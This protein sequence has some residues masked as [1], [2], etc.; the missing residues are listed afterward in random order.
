M[1]I[2]DPQIA[3]DAD[4]ICNHCTEYFDVK[5][6]YLYQGITG[7]QKLD[8]LVGEVR[9]AGR[10]GAY[11]CVLGLSGGIDSSYAAYLI[12]SMGLRP[13]A[14]HMD[15]GWDSEQSVSNI[16]KMTSGLGIDY[17]SYVLDWEEFRELQLSFLRAA[18]PEA[19]TPTDMAIIAAL[20]A[21]AAKYRVKHIVSAGNIT[22]EGILPKTWHYNAKDA[23]YFKHIHKTFGAG[24]LKTFPVFDY[25]REVYY[26]LVK[27]IKFIYPLDCVRF[28]RAE[29]TSFLEEKFDYRS[30]GEK[31]SESRYT[32]FIQSYYLFEKFG[33][34]YRRARLSSEICSGHTTRELAL[35]QLQTRPFDRTTIAREKQYVA[36]KLC[37]STDELDALVAAP[38]KRY[39]DYPN[40]ERK[41]QFIYGLYLR[42]WGKEKLANY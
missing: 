22:T 41:L 1:D 28:S 5:T 8:E 33:L 4:G 30:P 24:R 32:R 29:I 16:K 40:D 25:K 2:T 31:H 36:K 35:E 23:R 21:V 6:R 37:I 3:F 13:L 17:E 11:D 20:H 19:E 10:G 27:R 12:C 42:L 7:K 18:V 14:V 39:W 15:N 26:K 38:A 34:D 9:R